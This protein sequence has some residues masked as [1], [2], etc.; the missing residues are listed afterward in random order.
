MQELTSIPENTSRN[1]PI[2]ETDDE[3]HSKPTTA[4]TEQRRIRSRLPPLR[5]DPTISPK[6][7]ARQQKPTGFVAPAS[8]RESWWRVTIKVK[9]KL[10]PNFCIFIFICVGYTKSWYI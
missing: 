4:K 1:S 3:I 10:Y 7:T 2:L 6:I 9:L 8:D 5:A